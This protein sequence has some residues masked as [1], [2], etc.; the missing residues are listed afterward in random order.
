VAELERVHS[1]LLW[2]ASAGHEAGF[3]SFFMYV[4]RDREI[5][6]DILETISGNRV[7]YAI[8]TIGGVRRDLDELQ[9]KH[10]LDSLTILR[11][12][13]EYYKHLGTTEPSFV[14]RL[15]GVGYLSKE[16]AISLCAVGPT[17]RASGVPMDVRK[18]NPY[19]VYDE[20][21]FKVCTA[22]TCDV[23]GRTVV[24]ILEILESYNIMEYL[25]K[26]LPAG[27]DRRACS[28]KA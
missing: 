21:P 8:N 28:Q 24:R 10:I 13:S 18:D 9:I 15:A 2:L 5:V 12:R 26:N 23:L 11:E 1:H 4:W 3:D 20:I 14:A 16:D 27:T 25:L 17:L 7:H 19:A 6:M 22:E